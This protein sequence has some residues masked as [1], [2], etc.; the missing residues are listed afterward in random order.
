MVEVIHGRENHP[1]CTD[2]ALC[3]A[4]FVKLLLNRMKLPVGGQSFNGGYFFGVRLANRDQAAVAE[5]AR[6]GLL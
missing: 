6:L 4:I 5:A 3:A 1:R 2:T